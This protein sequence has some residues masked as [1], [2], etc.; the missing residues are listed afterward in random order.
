MWYT[1]DIDMKQKGK[2][3]LMSKS[4][5][6]ILMS[7]MALGA[8]VAAHTMNPVHASEEQPEKSTIQTLEDEITTLKG[9]QS[10]IK[11]KL[12]NVSNKK[13]ARVQ[14]LNIQSQLDANEQ[15]IEKAEQSL[16][17]E[18]DRIAEEERKAEENKKVQEA[19]IAAEK[20]KKEAITVGKPVASHVDQPLIASS[21]NTYPILQCTW[22]VKALAPWVGNN[23]G[24]AG[25]W[26]ASAAAA[27]FQVGTVPV[28]GSVVVW[29]DGSF[30]HVAYVT[31]VSE[32]GRIQV[33]EA[34]FGGSA[35]AP[36]SRGIGN[37]RGWFN[38]QG[39]Q[40]SVSYIYNNI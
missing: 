34:N 33:L 16:Q 39:I 18:K 35:Y 20:A 12:A 26:A 15:K 8:A 22:G 37:Y 13:G 1:I 3:L 21:D 28:A 38:P 4:I 19:K 27:G 14:A 17:S 40:G 23:W 36:D 30:G 9:T 6:K 31:D 24:H 2:R 29:N 7:T 25:Q 5:H 11:I 32:D 10:S